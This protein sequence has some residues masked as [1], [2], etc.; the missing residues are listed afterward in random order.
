MLL[1]GKEAANL[2]EYKRVFIAVDDKREADTSSYV[3]QIGLWEQEGW[4][5]VVRAF[6]PS[7]YGG[8]VILTFKR[9]VDEE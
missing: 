1:P 6:R 4:Q 3:V 9:E 2:Y 7:S 8:Y 5:F